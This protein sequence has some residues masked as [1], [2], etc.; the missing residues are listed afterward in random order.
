MDITSDGDLQSSLENK[1]EEET[2][3]NAPWAFCQ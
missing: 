3:A 1:G 2:S